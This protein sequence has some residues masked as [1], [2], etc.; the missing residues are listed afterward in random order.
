M[1]VGNLHTALFSWLTARNAGGAFILRIEDTDEVRST[2]EAL[3]VIYGG[4]RWLDL[5]WDE[6]PDVGGPHAPYVQSERLDTYRQSLDALLGQGLAYE[7]FCTPQEL[8]EERLIMRARGLP[9]RYSGRCADLTEAQREAYRAEGRQPCVRFRVKQTGATVIADRIQGEVTYENALIADSVIWKTSG[10]PT[11]HFAVV[12]DDYL[13]QVTHVIRGVEHLPN[14]QIHMQL[15]EALGFT[16]P[17]YAHLPI[18]LGEDRTKLSKRHGSVA[19]TDYEAQGYLREAMFNF[20]ALLGWSPGNEQEVLSR[21]D[22]I[23]RFSLD[24]CSKAPAVFD[25]KK[26]EWLNGQYITRMDPR[27]IAG[28]VLPRL[29]AAGLFETDPS[30]ERLEWLRQVVALMQERTRLLS[31]FETWASYLFTEEYPFEQRAREQWLGKPETAPVLT[32]LADHLAGLSK[33]T[34]EKL[35]TAVRQLATGLGIKAAGVIHPCRSAVT[36][37]TVGPSLFHLLELLPRETVVARLRKVAAL[38]AAGDLQPDPPE[39]GE[40]PA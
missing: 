38:V 5:N 15:Q 26:A 3:D 13:M 29:Q 17:V 1:H 36:G 40:A 27:D 12:V 7:C 24:S 28:L 35:E 4:L 11:F 14:T 33:W 21:A 20:L 39:A 37:T 22:T 30:V 32:A 8:E 19:V 18:I 2:P 10:F 6:G 23:S 31:V 25:L 9:P 34:A 16:T